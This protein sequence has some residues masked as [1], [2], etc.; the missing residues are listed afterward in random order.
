[1]SAERPVD[2]NVETYDQDTIDQ[3]MGTT[4]TN[5]DKETIQTLESTPS[6]INAEQYFVWFK[7]REAYYEQCAAHG[8][9]PDPRA[10]QRYSSFCVSRALHG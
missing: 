2:T 10:K 3:M 4:E 6:S 7:N 5:I 8:V 1:M 9:K